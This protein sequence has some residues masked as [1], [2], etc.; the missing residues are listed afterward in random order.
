MVFQ[1]KRCATGGFSRFFAYNIPS[2]TQTWL[3]NALSMEESTQKS[4]P[5]P[6]PRVVLGVVLG[7][8]QASQKWKI[9]NTAAVLGA[10]ADG[11]GADL[12]W[13]ASLYRDVHPATPRI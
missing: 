10:L 11:L 1:E 13:Q 12:G 3:G 8:C 7:G 5:H 9:F 2:G 6:V 4:H